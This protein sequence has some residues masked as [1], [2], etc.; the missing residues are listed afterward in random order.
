MFEYAKTKIMKQFLLILTLIVSSYSWSQYTWSDITYNPDF[1][2]P[3]GAADVVMLNDKVYQIFDSVGNRIEV[4]TYDNQFQQWKTI[5]GLN[6][7]LYPNSIQALVK[8]NNIFFVEKSATAFTMF[9]VD[10]TTNNIIQLATTNSYA[11]LGG[12]WEF[13]VSSV[14]GKMFVAFVNNYS[15]LLLNEFNTGTNTWTES[16]ITNI[17][18]TTTADISYS[19]I[20]L[21]FSS[22][23]IYVGVSGAIQKMGHA[24]QTNVAA[25]Q[26]YNNA[27][28]NDGQLYLNGSALINGSF[29]FSGNGQN[30]P[31]VTV[32]DAANNVSYEKPYSSTNLNVISGTDQPLSFNISNSEH[33]MLENSAYVFLMSEFSPQSNPNYDQF[34]VYRKDLNTNIWDSLGPKIEMNN[35]FLNTNSARISLENTDQKH[36]S[37]FY[38]STNSNGSAITKVLNQK[39]TI[40]T[41]SI[42]INTGL[43]V[44]Q[45]QIYSLIEV[46][47]NDGDQVN[48]TSG[49]DIT[50]ALSSVQF[51]PIGFELIG[52]IGITKFAVY[53][54]ISSGG[55]STLTLTMNDGW[56]YISDTLPVVNIS[57]VTTPILSFTPASPVFCN[58]ENLI[59]LSNYVNYYDQGTFSL[60][61]VDLNGTTINGIQVSQTASTG[62]IAYKTIID[63]C[64]VNT[65]TVYGFAI[66]GT[67]STSVNPA[68]C[69]GTDGSATVNYTPGSSTTYTV[70]WS[71]GQTAATINGLNPGAYYYNVTDQ[72]DCHVTGFASVGT[73]SIDIT[74][75]VTNISCNGAN[76][77]SISI[78]V[79][80]P[81]NYYV[82]WSN[83]K[84]TN[85]ITDLSP[86]NYWVTVV[87]LSNSCQVTYS[88]NITEPAP[89]TASF[90]TYD[91]D[92]GMS[93]GVISG[94]Y[95]GGTAPYTYSWLGT[96]QTTPNLTSATYGYYQVKVTD[97]NNCVDTFSY[98]LND[99]QAIDIMDSVVDATCNMSNGA[100]FVEFVQDA[101]GGSYFPNY[102]TWS[103]GSGNYNNYNLN[104]GTYT[105]LVASGI[106]GFNGNMC[107]AQKVIHVGTKA[108]L[109]QDICVVTVDSATTTNLVIWEKIEISG[110]S[111]YKIYREDINAGQF[112]WI[113]TVQFSNESLFND[114]VASP[115]DRSWRYKISAV[116]ECG[117]EGPVS[118]AHKTLHL[119][120][121][122]NAGNGSMDIF[123]DDYE[124][125]TSASEYVVW[126]NSDQNGWE[127]LV[128]SVAVGTTTFSDMTS[129]GLTGLDY[130]VE[131]VLSSPCSAE[132]AQDFNT[133]RS[134]KDKGQ[135]APGEGTGAS[136]NELNESTIELSIYPNP[137]TNDLNVTISE[138]GI[139][140][141][142]RVW[143]IH[144]VEVYQT[145]VDQTNMT[146]DLS[147]ISNGLYFITVEGLE[148]TFNIVK[149]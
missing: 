78:V 132:K 126:R 129:G 56:G 114:V 71:T 80:G 77:G 147:T 75:T 21:Y 117:I 49:Y 149:Q 113:D 116:N 145:V 31:V 44:G 104:S 55:N 48:I 58:N 76:D 87:D 19:N 98:N 65:S 112:N 6:Y 24:P 91:P 90:T 82:Y 142:L 10:L 118:I 88:Y 134:N 35:P 7:S 96:A 81:A 2:N 148:E 79:G 119:N 23:N 86:G 11:T 42:S 146:L 25:F 5:A 22:T 136:N 39:P 64:I 115:I 89:I 41:S 12:N 93:N 17:L 140:K 127:A 43:C 26:N 8:N 85:T 52:G 121:I 143:N 99:Y 103:N 111:H 66:V 72:H 128:P 69:G 50:G 47:D 84:T 67:A 9:R 137:F 28:T 110:I 54:T 1:D 60:N 59:D 32:K 100:V 57:T 106:S 30:P 33:F 139:N 101:N 135:F 29:Y 108:P 107:Y 16:T 53:G 14:T 105:I 92:C 68:S 109:R 130:F 133:T 46:Y 95:N 125:P 45:N 70:E 144:G 138:N 122:I 97:A 38:R 102:V 94:T 124:G 51:V 3:M 62:L 15:Q 74:P 36:L 120:S 61:G 34:Y 4:A 73:A 40:N 27:G 20:Q 141:T 131:M 123:W 18:N 83:G 37:V 13:K 63:G